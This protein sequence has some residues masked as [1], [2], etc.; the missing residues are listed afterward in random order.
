[1]NSC[2]TNITPN[3]ADS[4]ANI[5]LKGKGN[6]FNRKG[7]INGIDS[8]LTFCKKRFINGIDSQLTFCKKRFIN[9]IDSQLTFCK[10]RF[11]NGIDS[12]LTFSIPRHFIVFIGYAVPDGMLKVPTGDFLD[13]LPLAPASRACMKIPS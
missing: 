13:T 2:Y 10:K 12:Q 1:M 9:G 4:M 7:Y 6:I 5:R 8:Q 3:A 11:I